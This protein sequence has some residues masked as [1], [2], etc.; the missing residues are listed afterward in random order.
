MQLTALNGWGAGLAYS[1]MVFEG[2]VRG[3]W[4]ETAFGFHSIK[5]LVEELPFNNLGT[6]CRTP[7]LA[8]RPGQ[9]SSEFAGGL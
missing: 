5:N 4:G 6:Q 2:S 3:T 8:Y 7:Y 1:P 9:L